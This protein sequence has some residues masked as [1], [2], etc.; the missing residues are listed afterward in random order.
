M[1]G[2][3][4]IE[5]IIAAFLFS[6]A[7]IGIAGVSI[8]VSKTSFQV[9]R[10]VV[11][12]AIA[13]DKIESIRAM[14][15]TSIGTLP[16]GATQ[17]SNTTIESKGGI[18]YTETLQQNQQSYTITTD[19]IPVD[20]PVNGAV[21]GTLSFANADY[22]DIRI[23]VVPAGSVGTTTGVF[24]ASTII[25]PSN[26]Q[27]CVPGDPTACQFGPYPT[28]P[29]TFGFNETGS[30]TKQEPIN[31]INGTGLYPP[32]YPTYGGAPAGVALYN[33]SASRLKVCSIK[34]YQGESLVSAGSYSTSYD[35]FNATWNGTTNVFDVTNANT[36]SNS[37]SSQFT[38]K[39]PK[40]VPVCTYRTACPASGKCSAAYVPRG[41]TPPDT[42][43]PVTCKT[44][45]DCDVGYTCTAG[46]CVAATVPQKYEYVTTGDPKT[47]GGTS[48][49]DT[50]PPNPAVFGT[51][52][53][54]RSRQVLVANHRDICLWR[55]PTSTNY[56]YKLDAVVS[57]SCSAA[58]SGDATF[59]LKSSGC[60]RPGTATCPD[61]YTTGTSTKADYC[62]YQKTNGMVP[63][64]LILSNHKVAS[65]QADCTTNAIPGGAFS[66][67][68][69]ACVSGGSSNCVSD[70]CLWKNICPLPHN[71]CVMVEYDASKAS[72]PDA[73]GWT[74]RGTGGSTTTHYSA[75]DNPKHITITDT[76]T[77]NYFNYT[78][79]NID[80]TVF[81]DQDWIYEITMRSG[82]SNTNGTL[83]VGPA[84][85]IA[86]DGLK[87]ISAFFETGKLGPLGSAASPYAYIN[88]ATPTTTGTFKT[89]RITYHGYNPGI[90][91]D[92][93]D[94]A[95]DGATVLSGIRRSD[96]YAPQLGN[97][98]R[99]ILFGFMFPESTGSMDVSK[100]L[101]KTANCL[102]P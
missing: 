29:A 8:L 56:E 34:G 42:R 16:A 66:G 69:R 57:T 26:N 21:G 60:T 52:W 33:D 101:F 76:S 65:P 83:A 92:A 25:S 1:R 24:S 13:T 63:S 96:G 40:A 91:D 30:G 41:Y 51:G 71:V 48:Q 7:I 38:C 59:T 14:Q 20:D 3:T 17:Q 6:V 15:Y 99:G 67:P 46:S 78:Y 97:F 36:P 89:Y 73:Q 18:E 87:Y 32:I 39:T 23:Q 53:T 62:L 37:Q 5:V 22:K 47:S 77:S 49:C 98:D 55:K 54:L 64:D 95:V 94:I 84:Q 93:Y 4:V 82:S 61:E 88:T 10:K 79:E 31:I 58:L 75:G 68:D 86:S 28:P 80:Q 2:F 50:V 9:E 85:F 12:Q 81:M 74:A 70:V 35:N 11:A 19:I 72:L 102:L 100:V 44:V 45:A 90:T 27:S 43:Y